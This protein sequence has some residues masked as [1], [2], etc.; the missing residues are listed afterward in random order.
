MKQIL[1]PR[2]AKTLF[3]VFSMGYVFLLATAAH[4]PHF[5]SGNHVIGLTSGAAESQS[6][7][8]TRVESVY[9]SVESM[10]SSEEAFRF[11]ALSCIGRPYVK[12]NKVPFQGA[13]DRRNTWVMRITSYCHGQCLGA[14]LF[15]NGSS[16]VQNTLAAYR[17]QFQARSNTV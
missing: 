16:S 9:N 14:N 1:Q 17:T 3:T 8:L 7:L 2:P 15:T 12:P 5:C 10:I 13:D 11:Q 4:T 6:Q